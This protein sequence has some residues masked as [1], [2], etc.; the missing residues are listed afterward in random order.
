MKKLKVLTTPR[1]ILDEI[2]TDD[3]ATI[4]ELF[5][6][7]AVLEFY[8]VKKLTRREKAHDLVV[9]FHQKWLISKLIVMPFA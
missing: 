9:H 5:S 4:F 8:D 3:A 6:N 7:D 1:L 2:G